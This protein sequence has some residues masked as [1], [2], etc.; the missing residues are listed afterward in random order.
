M[1][2]IRVKYLSVRSVFL[3]ITKMEDINEIDVYMRQKLELCSY[4]VFVIGVGAPGRRGLK[5]KRERLSI[6]LMLVL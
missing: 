3:S 1:P 6:K 4:S 2:K 5:G